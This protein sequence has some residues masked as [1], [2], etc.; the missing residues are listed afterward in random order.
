SVP[1]GLVREFALGRARLGL[2]EAFLALALGTWLVQGAARRRL[3]LRAGPQAW[4]F[5]FFAWTTALSLL[6]ATSVQEVIPEVVKW[7]EVWALYVMARSVLRLRWSPWLIAAALAAGT[8]Q[9]LLGVYQFVWQ[10]GPEPFRLG[11]F[12]RAFGTFAQPN[13]YAGYLGM[14]VPLGLSL[15][16]WT[17]SVAWRE[18][19]KLRAGA[20]LLGYGFATAVC[21]LGIVM[22]WSRGAWLGIA[23]AGLVVMVVHSGRSRLVLICLLLIA[24]ITGLLSGF[25]LLPAVISERLADLSSFIGLLNPNAVE[26]TDANFSVYERVAHWYAGIAMFADHPWF[27][28]GAG[29]FSAVYATYALARWQQSLGHAHNVYIN[30]AAETGLVGLLSFLM[31]WGGAF[32]ITLRSIRNA[33]GYRWAVAVGVLGVLVHVSVHNLFDNLFVQRMYLH[34]ALLLALI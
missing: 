26:I 11:R 24:A 33:T 19:R 10:A 4:L 12:L 2:P 23:A 31:M 32:V 22:S 21:A 29:N 30:I 1:F 15:T 14:V 8:L 17:F 9:G 27:G 20:R 5:A 6:V 34:W 25:G 7:V 18:P 28:V 3:E 13:P 16:L